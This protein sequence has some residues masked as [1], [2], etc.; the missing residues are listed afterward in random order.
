MSETYVLNKGHPLRAQ[1]K[2]NLHAMIDRLPESKSWRVEIRVAHR[3]RTDKQLGALFGVAYDRIM[4]ATGLQGDFEKR[5]LHRDF[6]GDFFGWVDGPLGKPRPRRTTTT[7]EHG[8]ESRIDTMT[9]ADFYDFIQ[10]RAAE[11]GI[12]VPDPD[13]LWREHLGAGDKRKT[14]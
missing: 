10:R 4:A 8:E 2:A 14:A 11:F 9:M 7:D 1:V 12:D 13:P 3:E 6:C 5:K